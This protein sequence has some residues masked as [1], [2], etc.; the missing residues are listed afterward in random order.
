MLHKNS[1][2]WSIN[3]SPV[4]SRVF[5]HAG[6]PL[7]AVLDQMYT[8]KNTITCKLQ[9]TFLNAT[10]AIKMDRHIQI[11]TKAFKQICLAMPC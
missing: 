7:R 8:F 11:T 10:I 3:P 5:I 6:Y 4:S 9:I 1:P 2:S